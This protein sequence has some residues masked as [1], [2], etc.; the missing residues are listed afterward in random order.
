MRAEDRDINEPAGD[1]LMI[2]FQ[3]GGARNHA[4]GAAH[5]AQALRKQ[6]NAPIRAASA[7]QSAIVVTIGSRFSECD[8]R[9][10]PFHGSA[11]ERWTYTDS[12][13]VTNLAAWLGAHARSGQILRAA[14]T[15]RRVG[16]RFSLCGLDALALKNVSDAVQAWEA[17]E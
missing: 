11:A 15:A 12:G 8:F 3:R 17:P 7:G 2:T 16:R 9:D 10:T 4:C 14:G 13:P 6:S 1:G 5:A